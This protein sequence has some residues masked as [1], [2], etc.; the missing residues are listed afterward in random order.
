MDGTG[1]LK[2]HRAVPSEPVVHVDNFA[3]TVR[4]DRD[5]A[6]HVSNDESAL[7]NMFSHFLGDLVS[8]CLLVQGVEHR[9]F[10]EIG[11][12]AHVGDLGHL[13][14]AYRVND[15]GRNRSCLLRYPFCDQPA[16]VRCVPSV[17]A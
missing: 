17:P 2:R 10:G 15:K 1:T 5:S 16:E 11:H 12:P 7:I 6:S 9:P 4:P 14:Y 3:F 8:H 13:V